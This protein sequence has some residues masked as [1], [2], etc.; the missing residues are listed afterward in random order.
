MSLP[1]R[2]A[3]CELV[4]KASEKLKTPPSAA[5]VKAKGSNDFVTA[6][7]I[8]TQR[9]VK[10]ML[11]GA[12]PECL[13]LG[14]EGEHAKLTD[15]PTF[16]L[17][18]IDGTTNFIF[19]YRLSA[20]SLALCCEKRPIVAVVYNP[21]TDEMFSAEEGQGSYLGEERITVSTAD[22]LS[23]VV[24]GIGTSPYYKEYAEEVMQV[25][26]NLYLS[27]IDIRR[28]G[29]ASLDLCYTAAARHG[30]FVEKLLH[31]WDYAAGALILTEAGGKITD[32]SGNPLSFG[33][34]CEIA[35]S[36]GTLHEA[37]ISVLQ[38]RG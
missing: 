24:A 16:V 10:S 17:D 8:E 20:I 28:L 15:A 14:E 1:T 38:Q 34:S 12:Y 6:M 2:L 3:L 21:F 13:F 29:S 9:T 33:S 30:V 19:G 23:Q 25:A 27:C 18:P 32:F 4:R 7:D 22:H 11:A 26:K 37:L 31:V 35:A 5:D 36:N